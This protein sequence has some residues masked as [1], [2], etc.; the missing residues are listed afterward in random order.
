M[1]HKKRYYS[2]S[3]IVLLS[4]LGGVF[5]ALGI[6]MAVIIVDGIIKVGIR[7]IGIGI[8][9]PIA[10]ICALLGFGILALV[11]GGKQI[12]FWIRMRKTEKCGRDAVAKIIGQKYSSSAKK[13]NT[14]IRYALI[15]SYND[16]MKYKKFTTDYLYDINEQRYLKG[17][18]NIHIKIDGNFVVISEPFPSEIYKLDSVY[19]IEAEFYK[20]KPVKILLRLWLVFF[21]L[22]LAFFIVCIAIGNRRYTEA[23]ILL[24]FAV[25]LPFVIPLAFYLIKWFG[26]KK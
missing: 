22:S 11:F 6:A 10:M 20:Q 13:P 16:G 26:R 12:Y 19:G 9:M 7:A 21:L 1:E 25:H 2:I 23:A 18:G 17:L 3:N 15:L 4:A 8:L 14:R 24:L 5:T